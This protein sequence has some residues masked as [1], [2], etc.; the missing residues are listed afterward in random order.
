MNHL[1]TLDQS[2]MIWFSPIIITNWSFKLVSSQNYSNQRGVSTMI[3]DCDLIAS[4]IC[5]LHMSKAHF[6][7]CLKDS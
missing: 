3:M 4:D 6:E 5:K 2:T 7:L 1:E